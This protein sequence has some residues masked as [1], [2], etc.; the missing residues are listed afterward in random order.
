MP[1]S[2]TYG[3][4]LV[5][6]ANTVGAKKAEHSLKSLIKNTKA[7]G[8]T[9]KLSVGAASVALAAYAKKS[10]STALADEKAQKTLAKTLKNVG[11]SF[12]TPSVTKYIDG[13]QRATGVSEDQLRPAFDKLVT[14]TQSASKAQDLLN[15]SLDVSA[16]TGKD[17]ESVSAALSKAYLGNNTSLSKL[18][19]GISKAEL[20]SM[21][22][23]Q[24]TKKLSV[25]FAGQAQTAAQ[26]YSGQ[27]D[28]LKVAANEASETIGYALIDSIVKL[29]GQNGAK[30]LATQMQ[31]LADNTANVI[32][33]LTVVIDYFKQLGAAMPSWLKTTMDFL[34]RF[35]PLGQAKEALNVL[36]E[37][38]A[39]EKALAEQRKNNFSDR[40][41]AARAADISDKK[42][43]AL[44]ATNKNI[45]KEKKDQAASDKLKGMFDIDAIQIAAALKGKISDLDRARLEGMA[46]LKTKGTDDDIAAIKKIEYETL[47][48]NA[49]ANDSQHL[50][51]MNTYDFYA[52]I[53]GAA[54]DTADAIAKLSFVPPSKTAPTGNG[55]GGGGGYQG[56][57]SIGNVTQPNAFASMGNMGNV[58]FDL[59]SFGAGQAAFESSIASYQA[60]QQ[61]T[62][63]VNVNPSGSGF[64]GNQDDFLRTVQMA[65]QIGGRNGYSTSGLATG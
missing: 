36:G 57:P 45:S 30:D 62:V 17:V 22:F 35:S 24:V 16:A 61:S 63:V 23:E 31:T 51:L 54:K 8:L 5:I 64:I 29:G 44:L 52:S 26:T 6:T 46:A 3:I 34:M 37:L 38:G 15:L 13:L 49:A 14:S 39:K 12:A 50:A 28:I 20:K 10:I 48:A 59:A 41:M 43:K 42:A 18:G 32:T 65:L 4:P 7:F 56:M 21:S 60:A 33:G 27:L 11:E 47:R 2:S 58:G 9:S 19:V 55:T 1:R 53:Y 40:G 25:L